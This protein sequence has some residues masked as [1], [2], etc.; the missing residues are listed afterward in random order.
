MFI[1]LFIMH[2]NK[3]SDG[4]NTF[5]PNI[6]LKCGVSVSVLSKSGPMG[7]WRRAKTEV[8]ATLNSLELLPTQQLQP[9]LCFS[10]HHI[11]ERV[12]TDVCSSADSG[13]ALMGLHGEDEELLCLFLFACKLHLKGKKVL[14]VFTS[15]SVQTWAKRRS[16]GMWRRKSS[17]T[18][19]K[20]LREAHVKHSQVYLLGFGLESCFL[21][22]QSDQTS[23]KRRLSLLSNLSW[24]FFYKPNAQKL[25]GCYL[26]SQT[27][28]FFSRQKLNG[29][30]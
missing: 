3:G 15:I 4:F 21:G 23:G 6:F 17:E 7:E 12:R 13:N 27:K 25:P 29:E 18:E 2:Q 24:D 8:S 11:Q 9:I 26:F 10:G 16:S 19:L 28:P 1:N 14:E 20:Q 5:Q 22:V 30:I